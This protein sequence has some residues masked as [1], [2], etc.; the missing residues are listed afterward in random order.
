M[1]TLT[2]C[3]YIC[4]ILVCVLMLVTLI[5]VH[6]QLGAVIHTSLLGL[7]IPTLVFLVRYCSC[8]YQGD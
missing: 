8:G 3:C 2:G 7:A 1:I 6:L 5:L 4:V